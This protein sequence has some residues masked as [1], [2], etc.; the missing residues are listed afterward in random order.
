VKARDLLLAALLLVLLGLAAADALRDGGGSDTSASLAPT[1]TEAGRAEIPSRFPRVP[2]RGRLVFLDD[3]GC[4]LHEVQVSTGEALEVP[5]L[6]TGCELWSAAH[7]ERIAY[8]LPGEPAP[9]QPF[10]FLDLSFPLRPLGGFATSAGVLLSQ[11]GLTGAWCEGPDR[12]FVL[13]LGDEEPDELDACPAAFT[14]DGALAFI[15][16]RGLRVG[17]R[18]VVRTRDLLVGALWGSDGSLLLRYRNRVERLVGGRVRDRVRLPARVRD[19]PATFAPNTCGAIFP[20]REGELVGFDICGGGGMV[21]S[22]Q[23][24]AAAWSPDSD[25]IAL[26]QEDGILIGRIGG[27]E[28]ATTHW[29]VRA[30][31]LAWLG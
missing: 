17:D 25:W 27:S 28:Q 22:A 11:D 12:G 1:T 20:G 18:L 15:V 26:A 29:P 13:E 5:P 6:E 8:A 24:L 7:G 19:R 16:P 23:A 9:L 21:G 14:P 3:V 4:R 31:A 10:R 2:A 30:R